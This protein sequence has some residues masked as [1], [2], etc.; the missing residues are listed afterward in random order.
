VDAQREDGNETKR[1]P[2]IALDHSRGPVSLK[3]VSDE[4]ATGQRDV[5][6]AVMALTQ[7]IFVALELGRE[8]WY[9]RSVVVARAGWADWG[10]TMFSTGKD[11][12]HRRCFPL[13]EC[14]VLDSRN[15][16]F[17]RRRRCC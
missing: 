1:E 14:V 15:A 7:Y 4:E 12:A 9:S 17:F 3:P 10:N 6:Y 13:I 2:G 11:K 8:L 5:A 16:T